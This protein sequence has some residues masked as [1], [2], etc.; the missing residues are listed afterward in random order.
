LRFLLVN[1]VDTAGLKKRMA[2]LPR[3]DAESIADDLVA[4]AAADGRIDPE[5]VQILGRLNRLLGLDEASLHRR[6]HATVAGPQGPTSAPA[7]VKPTGPASATP[8][9]V[10]LD[11]DRLRQRQ[12][13]TNR[14]AALLQGVFA[15]DDDQPAAASTAA[16]APDVPRVDGLDAAHT[17]FFLALG[18]NDAWDREALAALAARFRLMPDGAVDRLNEAAFERCDAPLLDGD[19]DTYTLDRE[20]WET[21]RHGQAA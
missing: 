13:S 10:V 4:V 18:E 20:T 21:L 16:A 7:A 15:G 1:P 8:P 14:V 12:E 19:D 6:L 9:G 3:A 11:L 17:G 5:E 2:G